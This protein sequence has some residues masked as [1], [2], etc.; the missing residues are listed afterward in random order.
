MNAP[1][2]ARHSFLSYLDE[3]TSLL[4]RHAALAKSALALDAQRDEGLLD[5]QAYAEALLGHCEAFGQLEADARLLPC[6]YDAADAH[7][8][9]GRAFA[10][11]AQVCADAVAALD[12]DEEPRAVLQGF[13]AAAL[14]LQEATDEIV[15]AGRAFVPASA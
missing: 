8:R 15:A 14:L 10:E 2:A 11:S 13:L 1:R 7:G 3:L 4:D 5:P 12:A 6:P 9:F